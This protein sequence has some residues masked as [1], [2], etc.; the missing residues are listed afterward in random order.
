[1]L[2]IKDNA[3]LLPVGVRQVLLGLVLCINWNMK[4]M[5]TS[6]HAST[7]E[8]AAPFPCYTIGAGNVMRVQ[9]VLAL[10][11]ALIPYSIAH[12]AGFIIHY[13]LFI[14][15]CASRFRFMPSEPLTLIQLV[16]CRADIAPSNL[17]SRWKVGPGFLGSLGEEYLLC[18]HRHQSMIFCLI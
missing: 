5:G 7:N 2:G 8:I 4:R 12:R 9:G 1:M 16:Y 17:V 13:S 14:I 18:G 11:F 10:F 6:C 3:A 15:L